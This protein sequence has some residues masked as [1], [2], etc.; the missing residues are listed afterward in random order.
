MSGVATNSIDASQV[1]ARNEMA[2]ANNHH[3]DGGKKHAHD[4]ICDAC[5][6]QLPNFEWDETSNHNRF[7]IIHTD[8]RKITR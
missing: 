8:K 5:N 4:N 3:F 6:G 7:S 2:D 1:I